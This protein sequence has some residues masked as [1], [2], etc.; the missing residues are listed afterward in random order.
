MNQFKRAQV[1]MLPTKD[2][3]SGIILS[4]KKP[5]IYNR[6]GKNNNLLGNDDSVSFQHLSIISDDE[7]KKKDW[8]IKAGCELP[9]K[10]SYNI[11]LCKNRKKIIATIDTSLKITKSV[12]HSSP[13][14]TNSIRKELIVETLPQPSQQFIERYI[15][16]YNKGEVIT[17]VLVEYETKCI[18]CG[19]YVN[20]DMKYCSY[21]VPDEH[22]RCLHD[23]LKVN[24]K[25]NTITIKKLKDS[26][27]REEV[28]EFAYNLLKATGK[29]IKAEMVEIRTNPHIEFT[30][31][32]EW[33]EENL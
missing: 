2:K 13:N 16:S 27:S 25:D 1:I 32:D 29:E 3:N 9:I 7:I 19:A 10:A 11:G 18:G 23:V 14:N 24:S 21:P 33:I 8:Y 4:N 20:K 15:E 26:W 17:D 12:T 22:N 31:V 28:I 30:G 5:Y 6:I